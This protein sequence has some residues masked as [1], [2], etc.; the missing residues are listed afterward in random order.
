[1][2]I[3]EKETDPHQAE[4]LG[5]KG[6]IVAADVDGR[7]GLALGLCVEDDVEG[8][9]GFDK[10]NLE[11]VGTVVDGHDSSIDGGCVQA[12]GTQGGDSTQGEERPLFA[13]RC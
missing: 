9:T 6:A 4:G 2:L 7:L 3:T 13:L 1:M 10:G 11:P 12:E 8:N 5:S